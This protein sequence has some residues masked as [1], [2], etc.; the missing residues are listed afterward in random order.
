M[1]DAKGSFTAELKLPGLRRLAARHAEL[2]APEAYL[3]VVAETGRADF[4][5]AI[6]EALLNNMA[7][8]RAFTRKG[9]ILKEDEEVFVERVSIW[10]GPTSCA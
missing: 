6:D 9:V 3:W 2:L 8:G 1:V 5:Q 4:G 7:T 10:T